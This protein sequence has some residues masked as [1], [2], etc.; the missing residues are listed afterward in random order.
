MQSPNI[1]LNPPPSVVSRT[2]SVARS[3]GSR[4]N[5]RADGV[6]T[7]VT[8]FRPLSQTG[9]S[10]GSRRISHDD[11]LGTSFGHFRPLSQTGMKNADPPGIRANQNALARTG[12]QAAEGGFNDVRPEVSSQSSRSSLQGSGGRE[13]HRARVSSQTTPSSQ[14][15]QNLNS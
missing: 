2:R 13:Y 6:G 8:N 1:L 14:G 15:S 7:P 4:R 3:E 10:N 11:A 9:L 5:S 12:L